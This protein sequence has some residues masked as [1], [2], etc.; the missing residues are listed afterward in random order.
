MYLPFTTGTHIHECVY[1]EKLKDIYPSV[2]T[3]GI[4]VPVQ[5]VQLDPVFSY[6]MYESY[7]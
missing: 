2:Y 1:V 7:V 6:Y 3:D 4:C 5:H